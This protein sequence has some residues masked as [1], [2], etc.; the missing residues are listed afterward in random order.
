ME[1][2]ISTDENL[3]AQAREGDTYALELLMNRFKPL[4]KVKAND[5]FLTGGDMEDLIQE[6]M[7]GLYKAFLDFDREKNVKFASFAAICVVRQIQTAIKAASRQKH[8]PLNSSLS[9][10]GEV[11]GETNFGKIPDNRSVNP[12]TLVLGRE[13]YQS[14]GDF[15]HDNLSS[16]EYNVLSLHISGKSHGQI[17]EALG[18]NKKS[19]DNTLQRVRRKIGKAI[20]D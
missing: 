10:S 12:E 11:M 1:N 6:G 9:L 16:L 2:E 18:K 13:A 19:V 15:I 14:I 17:A 4:V 3:V 8:I 20:A 7:I 5:Y